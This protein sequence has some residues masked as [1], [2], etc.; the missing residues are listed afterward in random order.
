MHAKSVGVVLESMTLAGSE[1]C[2]VN[3]GFETIGM[4]I[5]SLGKD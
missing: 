1:R 5:Q 4:T 2:L 3:G